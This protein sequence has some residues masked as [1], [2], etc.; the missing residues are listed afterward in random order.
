MV[1]FTYI[2]KR[3]SDPTI[4]PE[5]YFHQTWRMRSFSKIKLMKI[6]EFNVSS[7]AR[8]QNLDL[9]L[10]QSYFEYASREGSGES[11]HAHLHFGCW[12]T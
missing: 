3:Q 5:F 12:Q 6:S 8:D 4:S 10:L 9:S 11:A 2:S 7:G 1:W